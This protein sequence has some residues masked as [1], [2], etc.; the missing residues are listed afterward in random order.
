MKRDVY[1]AL[2]LFAVAL[3]AVPAVANVALVH[4]GQAKTAIYVTSQVMEANHPLEK[5]AS[6]EQVRAEEQ[7]QRLRESIKDLAHYLEKMP[8]A[9]V[10]LVQGKPAGN[11]LRV[12]ILIG[13]YAVEKYGPPRK[14]GAF[15]QGWR[16]AISKDGIGLIGES[17][18]STSYAIYEMLDRLGCRWFMP[19]ELGESI[20]RQSTI[21]LAD[22]DLL[23]TPST[24]YRDVTFADA[25]FRRRNRLG[26]FALRVDRNLES[27]ISDEQRQKHPEWRAI[28]NGKPDPLRLKWSQPGV[29]E[30]VADHILAS[31][32]R[33]YSPSIPFT[34]YEGTGFDES[35]DTAWDAGDWDPSLNRVS[36]TDRYVRFCN[37]VAERVTKKYPDVLFTITAFVQYSRPPVR[38]KLHPNIVPVIAPI[39]YCRAHAMTDTHICPSRPQVRPLL[40]GWSKVSRRLSY[41]PVLF[42]RVEMTVPFPQIHLMK[43]EL[44]ILLASNIEYWQPQTMPNFESMLPGLWLTLRKT[45][46]RD[47]DSDQVLVEFFSR[48]YG[49]AQ[50]PMRRYWT[51]F[52]DA[53]TN[54]PEHSG[55][56]YGYLTRFTPAIMEEARRTMNEALSAASTPLQ[57]QRVEI[58]DRSLRQ[59]ARLMHLQRDLSEGRLAGLD[60][61][62]TEW[63]GTQCTLGDEYADGY[64]FGKVPQSDLNMADLFFRLF[65]EESYLEGARIARE[66]SIVGGPMR[67]WKYKAEEKVD[68][69]A[70]G[71]QSEQLDETEWRSTDVAVDTW[72]KL[73][74]HDYYGTV[75]YRNRINVPTVPEG[76]KVY[77]WVSRG[78]G[79]FRVF[80]NGQAIPYVNARG[81]KQNQTES[82]FSKPLS[83]DITKAMKPG[84]DNTIVVQATRTEPHEL[85]TGG[86]MGP[87]YL[88]REK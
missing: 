71:W 3:G 83:F 85:G 54:S 84:E 73:G 64:S 24:V 4:R 21:T 25:N 49:A 40:E 68:G 52:D 42:H 5:G 17:D 59:F 35:L 22:A 41:T 61:R 48:F 72:Y 34:P 23:G 47:A 37:L 88:Y 57:Y 43:S 44:P 63:R 82:V 50:K 38:E 7:R 86:L 29:V 2:Y 39:T 18:E 15:K 36:I 75:W 31:L 27:Y 10:P 14:K 1:A 26:G 45:W 76:K 20:L 67:E 65:F 81:E 56:V 12:P 70:Q 13:K 87:V 77:M 33:S 30:A 28:I 19:G 53:W 32:D 11:D 58:Q 66:Y 69:Q 6:V 60:I 16:V 79:A 74:L 80:V 55:S 62:A 46:N 9:S 51:L 78:E 8:G